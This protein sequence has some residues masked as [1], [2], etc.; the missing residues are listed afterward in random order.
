MIKAVSIP[1]TPRLLSLLNSSS[2]TFALT[3]PLLHERLRAPVGLA[4]LLLR[5]ADGMEDSTDI[6][7]DDRINLMMQLVEAIQSGE[8]NEELQAN[9]TAFASK[10]VAGGERDVVA[11]IGLLFTA[12]SQ[13]PSPVKYILQQHTQRVVVRMVAWLKTSHNGVSPRI[14]DV[15]HLMDYMYAV[16]GIVGELLTDLFVYETPQQQAL[17]LKVRASDFG[18]ALQLTNI[19]KDAAVDD[20]EGRRFLPDDLYY[21]GHSDGQERLNAL[22]SLARS[23]IAVAIEYICLMA[24]TAVESRLFCLVPIVLSLGT[25]QALTQRAADAVDGKIVKIDRTRVATLV[26]QAQAAV[27][28]NEGVRTLHREL[29]DALASL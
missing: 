23:R 22:I 25:L 27:A 17:P 19:I 3:I 16:A 28:T 5:A 10:M 9:C 12:L 6:A 21:V 13:T 4:Y 15:G 20:A 29:D 24:P 2:R 14:D 11:N 8:A 1:L 7:L 18:A 26:T